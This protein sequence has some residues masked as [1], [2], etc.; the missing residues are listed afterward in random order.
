MICC[1][2]IGPDYPWRYRHLVVYETEP[3]NLGEPREK[4]ETVVPGCSPPPL[5]AAAQAQADNI[6]GFRIDTVLPK[7]DQ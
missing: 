3:N 4:G 6:S 7:V 5:G 1:R 2:S